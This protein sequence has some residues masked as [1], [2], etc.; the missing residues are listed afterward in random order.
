M[1]AEI[2]K[3]HFDDSLGGK[4]S[5]IKKE[6]NPWSQPDE[7]DLSSWADRHEVDRRIDK[8]DIKGVEDKVSVVADDLFDMRNP[9]QT[10]D[11]EARSEFVEDILMQEEKYGHWFHFRWRDT[12][13][14]FPYKEDY[15]DLRTYRNKHLVTEE[16]QARLLGSRA[17]VFGLSVGSNVVEQLVYSGIG[18]EIQIGDFDVLTPTNL[19]RIKASM[20]DVG[21]KKLDIVAKKVSELDPYIRQVHY[22]EGLTTDVLDQMVEHKPDVIFDE[23]DDLAMKAA[24]RV[25]ARRNN[26]PII[27][28][29]D[30]G[31]TSL[32][33]VERHDIEDVKPFLGRVSEEQLQKIL[34][35]E[36]SQEERQKIMIKIVG[37]SNITPR[38]LESAMSI[39]KTL[40]GL[41]QLGATASE[42]GALSSVAAREL[43]IGNKLETGRYK[44]SMRRSLGLQHQVSLRDGMKTVAKFIKSTRK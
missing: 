16:E 1:A 23:I 13:V 27:M 24:L 2:I 26:I 30:I 8:G 5:S 44:V 9:S 11:G 31:D 6:S 21:E 15:Q 19:N 33:D 38:I 41:P 43:L 32:I 14:R 29:T 20:T 25:F 36:M 42:G 10:S 28:A 17:A 34:D 35:G 18:G 40:G 39:D 37:L 4:L 12:L 3:S 7:F 22:D